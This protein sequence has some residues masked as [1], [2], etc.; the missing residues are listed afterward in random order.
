MKK[1]CLTCGAVFKNGDEKRAH[2]KAYPNESCKELKG[3][4]KEMWGKK[5]KKIAKVEEAE[6][7]EGEEY[8]EEDEEEEDP[9]E[10][11]ME[12]KKRIPSLKSQIPAPKVD[13]VAKILRKTEEA[14]ET[15]IITTI[16]YVSNER[17]YD[18]LGDV[19]QE[20]KL[21]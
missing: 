9:E 5:S 10:E 20:F 21:N 2:K 12:E 18:S 6:D 3:G 17:I 15:G 16:I 7:D 13:K 19:G 4:G 11:R 14:T 8:P 1:R